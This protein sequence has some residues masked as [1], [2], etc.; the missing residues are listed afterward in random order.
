MI[1]VPLH[2]AHTVAEYKPVAHHSSLLYFTVTDLAA[3]DPMYQY[4]LR[5]FI[6]LFMRSIADSMKSPDVPTRLQLLNDHF[7]YFLFQNVC[8]YVSSGMLFVMS[9]LVDIGFHTVTVTVKMGACMLVNGEPPVPVRRWWCWAPYIGPLC[10]SSMI[11]YRR[12]LFEKDKL[13]FAFTLA[14]KLKLDT[15]EVSPQDVRFLMTG[16]IAVGDLVHPNPAP[17]WISDKCWGELCRATDLGPAWHG[18]AGH[19]AGKLLLCRNVQEAGIC[20][21]FQTSWCSRHTQYGPYY[22]A[23]ARCD[24]HVLDRHA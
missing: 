22:M 20:V 2:A 7:T 16:G 8:R 19:V 15:G 13:L 9:C 17:D 18:L 1:H 23:P 11:T 12:S 14:L 10:C 6:E 3:I 21:S 5:W 4:S 24:V